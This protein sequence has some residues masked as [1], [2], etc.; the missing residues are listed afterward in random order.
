LFVAFSLI[1]QGQTPFPSSYLSSIHSSGSPAML[2]ISLSSQV[3]SHQW[4]GSGTAFMIDNNSK[5]YGRKVGTVT[6]GGLMNTYFYIDFKSGIA[7]S[8]YTQHLPFNHDQ[9]IALFEQFSA[10]IY[11]KK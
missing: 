5:D 9:T 2:I 1:L 7:A 3:I 10:I 8:I 4:D 11:T 6:G